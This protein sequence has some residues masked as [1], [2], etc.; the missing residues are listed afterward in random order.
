VELFH[1]LGLVKILVRRQQLSDVDMVME[2]IWNCKRRVWMHGGK[3]LKLE[4]GGSSRRKKGLFLRDIHFRK[5]NE[6]I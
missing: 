5:K 3:G 6:K 4:K 2:P 1:F